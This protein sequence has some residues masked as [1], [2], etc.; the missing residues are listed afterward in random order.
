MKGKSWLS[1]QE[2]GAIRTWVRVFGFNPIPLLERE[3]I[4]VSEE[5]PKGKE[6]FRAHCPDQKVLYV[7]RAKQH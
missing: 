2:I 4:G 3:D 1:P 6:F 7:Y 5:K